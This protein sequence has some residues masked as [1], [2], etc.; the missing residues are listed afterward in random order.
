MSQFFTKLSEKA[1]ELA[2]HYLAFVLASLFIIIWGVTGPLFNFSDTWQLVVNT[3][4]T[5]ITFLM[6]FLI[7]NAQNREAS[8]TQAKLDEI[9]TIVS[10]TKIETIGAEHLPL[11]DLKLLLQRF[12]EQ[13]E[14]IH[15][16]EQK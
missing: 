1:A 2:G 4:T 7:Q 10:T 11:N 13:S 5:I 3:S 9:L 8:A 15:A 6:V 14:A 16:E 12:E